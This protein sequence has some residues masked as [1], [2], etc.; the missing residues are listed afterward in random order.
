MGRLSRLSYGGSE[1]PARGIV[2][3]VGATGL[4][5]NAV[6]R[7]LLAAGWQ[8]R[9]LTRDPRQRRAR[10]LV[11][12]G[13]DV[14]RID[15]E[16]PAT[17]EPAFEG[18][19]GVYSVQNP[20]V[21][22]YDGEVR[23]GRNVGDVA[24]RVGVPHVVYSSAGVGAAS[25]GVGSWDT[26]IQVA[27]HLRSLDLP[28]TILRPMAFME[29]M[30][31]RRF[32]PPAAAWHVM[33]ALMGGD[34]PVGWLAVDDL[35]A[36]AA[37]VFAQRPRFV[38][39]ELPLASDV[40]SIEG[41]RQVWREVMGRPPRRLPLPVGVFERLAGTD[42]TTMWRWLRSHEIDLD[43]GPT[44]EIH[45]EALT[46]RGWLQGRSAAKGRTSARRGGEA[47]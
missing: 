24:A 9:A 43:T 33:P 30:T 41:C 13:A 32:F 21:S 1:V 4:Q 14:R 45:P 31:E 25:T 10:R 42:E 34:R 18:A 17:L 7:R 38:G 8:V 28:L 20:R 5:G 6:A 19:H 15:A 46:V 22:G 35:A 26:K 12:L 27:E 11:A 23:Q 16:D 40:L 36:V 29:L 3:V 47:A 44:R 39:R 37:T 2:A